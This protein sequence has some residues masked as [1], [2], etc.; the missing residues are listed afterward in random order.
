[1]FEQLQE[2][3]PALYTVGA[4]IGFWMV[5]LVGLLW[6]FNQTKKRW[7]SDVSGESRRKAAAVTTLAST[8]SGVR[9]D[10]RTL[11]VAAIT[12]TVVG[13]STSFYW[14][15]YRPAQARMDCEREATENARA[16]FRVRYPN[17]PRGWF[18]RSDEDSAYQSCMRARGLEK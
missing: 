18:V 15:S 1:L 7:K 5:L 6:V 14:F 16:M 3:I 8:A 10:W 11:A 12:V 17:G 2:K 9:A 13:L 4:T